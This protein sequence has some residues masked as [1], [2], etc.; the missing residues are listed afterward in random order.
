LIPIHTHKRRHKGVLEAGGDTT[1]VS[2]QRRQGRSY[3]VRMKIG[4]LC[5][6]IMLIGMA[7]E[8]EAGVI[9][10]HIFRYTV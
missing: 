5:G 1:V 7:R 4:S 2:G 9:G 8:I 6:I 3:P 10:Q